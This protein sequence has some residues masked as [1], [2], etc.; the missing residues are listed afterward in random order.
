GGLDSLAM[1]APMLGGSVSYPQEGVV[2]WRGDCLARAEL[3][4]GPI[5]AH[6]AAFRLTPRLNAAGRLGEAQL[7]L[8]LLLATPADAERLAA[9]IEEQNTERQRIQELVWI[10]ARAQAAEQADAPAIVVG[11]EGWHHGVVGIIAARL[12]DGFARP[13]IAIGFKNGEGRGSARTVGGVNLFDALGACREHLTRFGGHAGAAGLSIARDRLDDFRSAFAAE[14]ARQAAGRAATAAVE[15]DAEVALSDLDLAFAEELARL[16][17]FG[18]ANREPLFAL[19]GVVARTTRVVG[20]GHLQLTLDHGGAVSDAIAFGQGDDDPGAGAVLDVLA[21]AELD[22]FR[23]TR[24][25]RL[26]VTKLARRPN[27]D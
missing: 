22:T 10:E 3:T 12:V 24:R 25:A 16:G 2:A 20:K 27:A 14:A 6:Q 21:T 5:T 19:R 23:G 8:D 15:V 17:P 11:A 13:A 1:L 9:A 26:R 4:D 18:A 7:A